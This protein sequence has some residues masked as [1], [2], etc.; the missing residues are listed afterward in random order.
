M[1]SKR[2]KAVNQVHTF[3]EPLYVY[4]SD[5]GAAAVQ[6]VLFN[7]V[8][9]PVK[10]HWVVE[11]FYA[12]ADAETIRSI[13]EPSA[14][15]IRKRH[16]KEGPKWSAVTG[17]YFVSVPIDFD[18]GWRPTEKA[19]LGVYDKRPFFLMSRW[20]G[21]GKN[22]LLSGDFRYKGTAELRGVT[23]SDTEYLLN[24]GTKIMVSFRPVKSGVLDVMRLEQPTDSEALR[25]SLAALA[26]LV[27]FLTAPLQLVFQSVLVMLFSMH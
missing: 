11:H 9:R 25:T 16:Q 18:A 2:I 27:D 6:V 1:A 10:N 3:A 17:N 8:T 22:E 24:D 20:I 4:F 12:V 23:T 13:V 19:S 14:K 15:R 5:D 21:V 26:V 7:E